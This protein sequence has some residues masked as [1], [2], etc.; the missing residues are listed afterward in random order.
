MKKSILLFFS[1]FLIITTSFAEEIVVRKD[2]TR[3]ILNDDYTWTEI[4][5]SKLSIQDLIKKNRSHLRSGIKATEKEIA[6]AC[7]IYEQGWTYTMPR[8]KS[9]HASWGNTDVSTAWY[10]G[11]W[12]NSKTFKYSGI[13]PKKSSSGM[14][15]GDNQNNSYTWR[16]GGTPRRPNVFMFL[17]SKRNGPRK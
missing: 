3:I 6:I 10:N 17:L 13:I 9:K 5:S 1:L 15:L 7:E 16:N 8:P 12:Y 2:G 4:N 14:Y 11:F